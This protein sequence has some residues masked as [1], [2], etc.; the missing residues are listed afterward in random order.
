MSLHLPK[1]PVLLLAL[2]ATPLVPAAGTPNGDAS[3]R[4]DRRPGLEVATA[5]PTGENAFLYHRLG[6]L[7]PDELLDLLSETPTE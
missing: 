3:F 5:E 4:G 1:F 6:K 7:R 2:A